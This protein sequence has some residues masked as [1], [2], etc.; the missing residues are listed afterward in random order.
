MAGGDPEARARAEQARGRDRA[1][2]QR[3][4]RGAGR[5]R[6]AIEVQRDRRRSSTHGLSFRT[7]RVVE[8]GLMNADDVRE[9]IAY[10]QIAASSTPVAPPIHRHSIAQPAAV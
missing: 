7:N 9:L 2:E 1:A 10:G 8:E 6:E 3:T 4:A 5:R